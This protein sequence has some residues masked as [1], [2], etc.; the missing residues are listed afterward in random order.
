MTLPPLPLPVG[1]DV[2]SRVGGEELRQVRDVRQAAANIQRRGVPGGALRFLRGRRDCGTE[3]MMLF[4]FN[5]YIFKFFI[6][7]NKLTH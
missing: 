3:Q 5:L 4:F 6:M 2:R 7:F 1:Q